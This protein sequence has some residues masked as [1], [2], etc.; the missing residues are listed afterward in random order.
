[1]RDRIVD[2][3]HRVAEHPRV[4]RFVYELRNRGVFADLYQHD[5][6][7]ADRPRMDAYWAGISKHISEGDVV[8]DLGT[9]SGVLALFAARQG[10]RVHAVEHGPIIDAAREVAR[11]NGVTTI[12]FHQLHSGRLELP[13]KVDAIIHE[14][15][16]DALFDEHV[17][18]N[19]ADLRDRLLKPGGHVFPSRLRLFVE[20]VQLQ[21]PYRAPYAWQQ[22]THGVSFAALE[23]F[24]D[25]QGHAYYYRTF[26]PFP[27]DRFLCRPEPV[28][29]IDLDLANR[30]DLPTRIEYE[31][32]VEREGLLD[33]FAV[34]FAVHFDDEI[35]FSSSPDAP[36]TSWGTPLLRV[37]PRRVAPGESIRLELTADDLADPATWRWPWH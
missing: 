19:I 30:S 2:A 15:I 3:A 35:G 13:E 12:E 16:G 20:P 31:R 28:V 29:S 25:T 7:L 33:G 6:M 9:G 10:A 21:E 32:P 17:V 18:A 11:A 34:Y 27:F 4:R 24:G 37:S 1:M 5:R 26:R 36:P 14:Q 8:I 22:E 23:R